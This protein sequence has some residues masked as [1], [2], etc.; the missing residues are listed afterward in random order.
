[1]TSV[2]RD[3]ADSLG[4]AYYLNL[5]SGIFDRERQSPGPPAAPGVCRCMV[6]L[7][8]ASDSFKTHKAQLNVEALAQR[9]GIS[10]DDKLR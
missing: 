5:E 4:S 3:A 2:H 7:N 6:V 10:V 1:M 8:R 9:L